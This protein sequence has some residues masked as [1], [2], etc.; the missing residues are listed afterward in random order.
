MFSFVWVFSSVWLLGGCSVCL[1]LMAM[2]LK[3]LEWKGDAK[4]MDA[5]ISGDTAKE[6]QKIGSCC[7]ALSGISWMGILPWLSQPACAQRIQNLLCSKADKE[8]VTER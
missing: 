7:T 5:D 2:A 1:F 8:V 4:C 6:Q 3:V